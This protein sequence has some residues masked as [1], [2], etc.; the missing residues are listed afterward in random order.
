MDDFAGL[1]IPAFLRRRSDEEPRPWTRLWPAYE[2]PQMRQREEEATIRDLRAQQDQER[3]TRSQNRIA[4]ML[5]RKQDHA[6]ETWNTKTA[7]WEKV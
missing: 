1:E 6:D 4:K 3:R 7:R 2:E 5:A